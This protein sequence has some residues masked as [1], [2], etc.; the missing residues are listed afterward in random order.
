M[1]DLRYIVKEKAML[2]FSWTLEVILNN[3]KMLI[4]GCDTKCY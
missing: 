2:K 1:A 3:K 4:I